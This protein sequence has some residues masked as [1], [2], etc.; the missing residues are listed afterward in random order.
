MRRGFF[1][2]ALVIF[3]MQYSVFAQVLGDYISEIKGDTLVVKD[4]Y[5]MNNQPNSL[6]YALLLDS[7]DVP[8]GRVYELKANGYYPHVITPISSAKHHTVIIGA[9]PTQV[10]N[11]KNVSSSPPLICNEPAEAEYFSGI[12]A[13]GDLT[14][15][16]CALVPASNI[17]NIDWAFTSTHT[18]NLHLLFDNCLFERTL[19]V[20][21]WTQYK[22]CNAAFR[23]CYFVNMSGNTGGP[24]GGVY[25]SLD[26]QDTLL[27]ENCTH[28]MAQGNLYNFSSVPFNRIVI[29][30]NTFINCAGYSFLN[31][32]CQQNISLTNNIF[33]N[34]N[35]QSFDNCM[36]TD[37][38]IY[39]KGIIY[40]DPNI[41]D[42]AD[43]TQ[44]KF[45]TQNNLAY[46]DPLLTNC[47]S[48]LNA[49]RV[50]GSNCWLSQMEVMSP[51]TEQMF[52]DDDGYPFLVSDSWKNR[53][54]H[55]INPENLFT[56]QL[57]NLKSF[58]IESANDSNFNMLPA[59]RL[60]NITQNKFVYPDW[61]IPVDL[62]YDD[63]E[64]L[65][66]GIG[67]FP[68]GD[69]NWFPDK[70]ADWLYQRTAEYNKINDALN[71]GKLV[72]H[73]NN[74]SKLP[75]EFQLLQ[76]YPNPFN[77][78]TII[79]FS[80]SKSGYVTLKVFNS[81]GQQIATLLD[82]FKTPQNYNISFD[83]NGLASG[84]YFYELRVNGFS[85]AKKML[86]IR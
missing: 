37:A 61:P 73:I 67:G 68:L 13:G 40:I 46:W 24:L 29:N 44:I 86:L 18:P 30:H 48:I 39:P 23:N 69:L 25:E 79:S 43:R 58:V 76:N 59:W 5:E 28:I 70:K 85:A 7:L 51:E 55:F 82:S 57:E 83:G 1:L 12:T 31:S 9:N 77:P 19:W 72:T 53:M 54:P 45:L 26:A 47:D 64:L 27:I 42:T 32:G 81:L 8:K 4:Y 14:I 3:L 33:I 50:N 65:N 11:N 21:M 49:N 41:A 38:P 78:G 62:S 60:I 34:C 6:Y 52:N 36:E 2:F 63:Q 84:V 22:N 56:T 66:A 10:V 35:L 17:G 15:K 16:N 80:I 74:Q 71:T 75:I 20:F